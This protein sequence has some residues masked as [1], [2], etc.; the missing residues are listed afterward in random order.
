VRRSAEAD[1]MGTGT[2]AT[3]ATKEDAKDTVAV[4]APAIVRRAVDAVAVLASV[5]RE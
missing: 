1:L 2:A 3:A 5:R 4:L